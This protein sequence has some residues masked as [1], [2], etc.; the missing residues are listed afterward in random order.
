ML[1]DDRISH[2]MT[3]VV[4]ARLRGHFER[5]L[6]EASV[7]EIQVRHPLLCARIE[8]VGGRYCWVADTDSH[9]SVEW[10]H[11]G[12][13]LDCSGRKYIDLT[14]R[15]GFRV[16]IR[17]GDHHT[18]LFIQFHHACVDAI[19]AF[20]VLGDLLALYAKSSGDAQQPTALQP[21]DALQLHK[22][23]RTTSASKDGVHRGVGHFIK[24]AA[25]VLGR[26]PQTLALPT[27]RP[28]DNQHNR[29]PAF[30]TIRFPE[31]ILDRLSYVAQL[32]RA[33]LNDLLLRDV[34][35]TIRHWNQESGKLNPR[36]WFRVTMP[37]SLRGLGDAPSPAANSLGYAFITHRA[38][39]CDDP[40]ALLNAI[41]ERTK[42]IRQGQ[43]GTRFVR[44]LSVIDRVPFGMQLS[45]RANKCFSTV[46][47]SNIGDVTRHFTTRFPRVDGKLNVGNLVLEQLATAPP[48]RPETNA[49]FFWMTYGGEPSVTVQV[50]PKCFSVAQ[51]YALLDVFRSYV[52]RSAEEAEL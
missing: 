11:P 32:K 15:T 6:F 51:T 27:D 23:G 49:S 44:T 41:C 19:G 3:F 46:V 17:Q 38:E 16:W 5:V 14:K 50:D 34:L 37:T 26:R 43:L 4:H 47:F 35:L 2:P 22:R 48:I 7:E 13:Q 29:Y 33:T 52:Q 36:D 39:N 10:D 30:E 25:E 42:D 31:N 24:R 21:L 40:D 8:R 28:D 1:S 12:F 45:T 18:D 20:Q 9:T